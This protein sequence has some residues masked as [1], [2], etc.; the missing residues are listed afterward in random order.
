MKASLIESLLLALAGA[1]PGLAIAYW[2]SRYLARFIWQ[3]YGALALSLTPDARVIAFTAAVAVGTGILFGLLPAWRAASQ[4]PRTAI[5]SASARMVGGLGFAGRILVVFQLGLSFAI[6]AAAVLFGRSVE[7]ILH[8]DP[9]FSADHL[10][11]AQ[12]MPR[13]TYTGFDKAVYFRQLLQSLRAIPGVEAATL[14]HD[15]PVGMSWKTEIL[16]AGAA[17]NL[18]EITPDF[19]DTLRIPILRGRDFD[20]RDNDS[21]PRVVIVSEKLGHALWPKGDAI[22][23]HFAIRDAPGD[24][25]VVGIAANATLDDPRTPNAAAVYVPI[26]QTPDHLG[27]A[28]AIIRARGDPAGLTR[29]L[30]ASIESLGREYPLRIETVDEE[31]GRT[32]MPE[33]ILSLL[34][35]FF[36]ATALLLAG[37][38]LYGLLSYTVSR[39][40]SEI[41]V[42]VALGATKSVIARMIL[43]EMTIMVAAGLATGIA[44]AIAGERV[45]QALLYDA[46]GKETTTL[47]ATAGVLIACVMLAALMPALRAANVDPAVALRQRV[48]RMVVP[49]H[50]PN[51]DARLSSLPS[52]PGEPPDERASPVY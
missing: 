33:R 51:E 41:G 52:E 44:I 39:R 13:T 32:L 17:A 5:Q 20:L 34:T 11:V 10:L 4:D 48:R 18:H 23:R 19:F 46:A 50:C 35:G 25:Q 8:R 31:S 43:R 28:A 15:R 40:V 6:V 36:G 29:A 38:G 7:G 27:W 49:S 1:G 37:I 2:G 16:P 42:R 45:I 47:I 21:R 9:G 24:F 14:A 30:T 22:G 26:F 3:G 12:L